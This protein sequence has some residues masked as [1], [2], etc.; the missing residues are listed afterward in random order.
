M[1]ESCF[2]IRCKRLYAM[3]EFPICDSCL[4]DIEYEIDHG[5]NVFK[6]DPEFEKM[7]DKLVEGVKI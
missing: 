5:I 6:Q 7:V 4:K 3:V 2:C 1:I